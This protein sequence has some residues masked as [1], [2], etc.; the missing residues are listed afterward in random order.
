MKKNFIIKMLDGGIRDI[1]TDTVRS[2]VAPPFLWWI[3]Y[4]MQ[5]PIWWKPWINRSAH[6]PSKQ[7]QSG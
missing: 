1:S 3:I 6:T 4:A 2:M 5:I 7:E